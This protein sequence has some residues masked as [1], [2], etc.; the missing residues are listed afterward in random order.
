MTKQAR[1]AL[2]IIVLCGGC[3]AV[4]QKLPD[5][6]PRQVA[7]SAIDEKSFPE[8]QLNKRHQGVRPQ[9]VAFRVTV[10][11]ASNLVSIVPVDEQMPTDLLAQVKKLKFVEVKLN[12]ARVAWSSTVSLCFLNEP[13]IVAACVSSD[14][15]PDAPDRIRILG[16]G[17]EK[18]LPLRPKGYQVITAP[19]DF[20]APGSPSDRQG[21]FRARV[22][23]DGTG[24]ITDVRV[25]SGSP[26]IRAAISNSIRKWKYEPLSWEGKPVEVEVS[27]EINY[28]YMQ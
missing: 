10:D 21:L 22:L 17:K 3:G 23:I 14:T 24:H 15:A 27:F 28:T 12:G 2:A 19:I 18:Y 8:E 11:D 13:R 6:L 4:A 1:K 7:V 25:A 16:S 5:D 20:P 9:L 26:E